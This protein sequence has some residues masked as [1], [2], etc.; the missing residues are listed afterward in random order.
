MLSSAVN[1]LGSVRQ[2]PELMG[3]R[4]QH[5]QGRQFRLLPVDGA[6]VRVGIP[7]IPHAL[8]QVFK[9]MLFKQMAL[10]QGSWCGFWC[11]FRAFCRLLLVRRRATRRRR[12]ACR[13]WRTAP[14]RTRRPASASRT[15]PWRPTRSRRSPQ[16]TSLDASRFLVKT[17]C[18]RIK[19]HKSGTACSR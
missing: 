8:R 14:G 9:E 18:R 7:Q 5:R 1:L 2:L 15:P 16:S 13:R 10:F 11:T 6:K 4:L 3:L 17:G 12:R 19:P